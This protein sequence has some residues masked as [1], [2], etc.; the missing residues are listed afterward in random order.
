MLFQAVSLCD[1][2]G[3]IDP[4]SPPRHLFRVNASKH[5]PLSHLSRLTVQAQERRVELGNLLQ[6][7]PIGDDH[8]F[9]TPGD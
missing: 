7:W 8:R 5:N 9:P 3:G 2:G 1:A 4:K 6:A